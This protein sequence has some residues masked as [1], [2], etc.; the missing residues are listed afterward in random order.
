M[1]FFVVARLAEWGAR[2]GILLVKF[3]QKPMASYAVEAFSNCQQII[4]NASRNQALYQSKFSLPVI[5]DADNS[6]SGPLSGN[7]GCHCLLK[8]QINW[9]IA[10][11]CDAPYVDR[12]YVEKMY[13]AAKNS[14]KK[15]LDG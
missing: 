8:N 1:S 11:P 15:Y 5:S 13:C 10:S 12:E 14:Q 9:V 4:I 2:Q 6:H 7:A 3:N